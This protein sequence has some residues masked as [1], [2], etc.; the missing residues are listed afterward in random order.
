M[1]TEEQ[2]ISANI[3]KACTLFSRALSIEFL[4]SKRKEANMLSN[5]ELEELCD[6]IE[7][8]QLQ[9]DRLYFR[10]FGNGNVGAAR[11]AAQKTESQ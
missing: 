10:Y 3:A 7:N 1:H 9:L 2:K 6:A 11:I 8:A 4:A 5:D